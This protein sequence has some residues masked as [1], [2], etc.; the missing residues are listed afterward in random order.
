VK[1]KSDGLIRYA[2]AVRRKI[3]QVIA[4]AK[5]GNGSTFRT[6]AKQRDDIHSTTR[7]DPRT[8]LTGPE[9]CLSRRGAARA[10][11]ASARRHN[12]DTEC[13]A[14]KSVLMNALSSKKARHRLCCRAIL[15]CL[16]D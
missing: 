2:F 5:S 12:K 15:S 7:A 13:G 10:T 16:E 11:D 1:S 14:G 4:A 3:D 6:L 9:L 8:P